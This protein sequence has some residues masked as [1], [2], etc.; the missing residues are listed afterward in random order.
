[1]SVTQPTPADDDVLRHRA[2]LARWS[3][4]GKRVG[5]SLYGVAIVLFVV[6]FAA[7]YRTWM[8]TTI[9]ACMVVGGI[10]LVPAIVL[11]YGIKAAEREERGEAS[12]Y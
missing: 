2:A 6:G 10:I 5:Y 8:T 1:M 4:L 7:S 12:H 11:A 3:A 9:I